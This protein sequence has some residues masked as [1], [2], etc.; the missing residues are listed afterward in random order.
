MKNIK[1]K[2]IRPQSLKNH[3][4]EVNLSKRLHMK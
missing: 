3:I 4:I 2:F 1:E